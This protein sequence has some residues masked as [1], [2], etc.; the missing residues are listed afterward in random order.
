MSIK[1]FLNNFYSDGTFVWDINAQNDGEV[2]TREIANNVL[3]CLRRIS[4]LVA[5]PLLISQCYNKLARQMIS[6][7]NLLSHTWQKL[8]ARDAAMHAEVRVLSLT[9]SV[10]Y[11]T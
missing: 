11:F 3:S 10:L 5:L 6:M 2:N 9:K 1:S 4:F 8:A 7:H